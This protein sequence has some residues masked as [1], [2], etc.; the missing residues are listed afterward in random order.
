M[1]GPGCCPDKACSKYVH[2]RYFPSLVGILCTQCLLERSQKDGEKAIEEILALQRVVEAYRSD[3]AELQQALFDR[4]VP[5]TDTQERLSTIRQVRAETESRVKLLRSRLS[6]DGRLDLSRLSKDKYLRLRMNARN[7][8]ARIVQ[9][10]RERKFELER[11]QHSFRNV[12]NGKDSP[13]SS[14]DLL[15]LTFRRR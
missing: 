3:E 12:L 7:L 6:V 2:L 13:V 1:E 11:L 10:L 14:C 4:D 15:C 5:I 8:K 9:R